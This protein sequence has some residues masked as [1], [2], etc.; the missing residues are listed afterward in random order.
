MRLQLRPEARLS[1]DERML[2]LPYR[3][4]REK[5]GYGRSG[6]GTWIRTKIDGVRVRCSTVELFP[7][8]AAPKIGA[9][10]VD[11]QPPRFGTGFSY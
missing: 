6:W 9:R 4:E 7:S 5:A 1:T 8:R 2:A 3:L 10:G 11:F